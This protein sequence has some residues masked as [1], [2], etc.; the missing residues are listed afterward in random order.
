MGHVDHELRA[1]GVGDRAKALPVD[2]PRIRGRSGQNELRLVFVREL[3]G[4]VVVDELGIRVH[5][6]GDDLE[7][8]ARD[9]HRRTVRQVAAVRKTHAEDRVAGLERREEHGLIGLGA[10]VRLHVGRIGVEQLLHPFQ[11]KLLG[12]VDEFAAA[13][14]ALA[15][16]ALGV[17]VGELRA[18][19][20]HDRDARVVLRRDQLDVVFLPLVLTGDGL[21]E[22]R[23]GSGERG[24]ATEHGRGPERR[25]ATILAS[26]TPSP[27]GARVSV[28]RTP[29]RPL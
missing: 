3:L 2:D 28:P 27:T 4:R 10:G 19:R 11:R 8:L 21:P 20:R 24:G 12:D 16:I 15:R 18:L 5:A 23:I 13:V 25:K 29:Q 9:V 17:L 1:D 26:G 7:P 22:F 6:I 14:V